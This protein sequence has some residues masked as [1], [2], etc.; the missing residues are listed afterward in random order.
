MYTIHLDTI[1]STNTYAKKNA[2]NFP[3]HDITCI[4]A[5]EQTAGRARQQK[6][7][8]SPFGANL[9]V[10]FFFTLPLKTPH[11]TA[12]GQVLAASLA[13]VLLHFGLLAQM[14]WPNDLY[15]SGKKFAGILCE[16]E[17]HPT[18]VHLFLG[19]GINVNL[20]QDL[21]ST[22]DQPATS[23][24]IETHKSWNKEFLLQK[25]QTTFQS[26]LALF[27]KEGFIPFQTFLNERLAFKG[28]QIR[29]FTGEEIWEGV[30]EG[31]AADGQLKLLLNTGEVKVVS[32]GDVS[33]RPLSETQDE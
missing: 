5:E 17:F 10:T 6:T 14:K 7:W 19:V 12:I 29:C 30:C 9:Y 23:L 11:L 4:Y 15:L 28:K 26:D 21:L 22:I 25:L 16:T 3:P 8:I 20:D 24:K 27:K 13:R 33:L 1:D 2:S 32:A 18:L 31:L